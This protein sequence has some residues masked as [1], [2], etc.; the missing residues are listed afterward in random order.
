MASKLAEEGRKQ[1]PE[2][3]ENSLSRPPKGLRSRR[4]G[5]GEG[6]LSPSS[7][8]AGKGLQTRRAKAS[9]AGMMG[10]VSSP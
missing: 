4:G 8:R 7:R 3:E 5:Q 10:L 6:S 1:K 2:W 9:R